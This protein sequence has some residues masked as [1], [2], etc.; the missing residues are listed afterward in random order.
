MKHE[1][2]RENVTRKRGKG[3]ERQGDNRAF[4]DR[5]RDRDGYK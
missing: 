2:T 5:E 3:R 1:I 4:S